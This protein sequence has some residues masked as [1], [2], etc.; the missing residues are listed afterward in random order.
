MIKRVFFPFI[1]TQQRVIT[2]LR[3]LR[4]TFQLLT[5]QRVI[6]RVFGSCQTLLHIVIDCVCEAPV[7]LAVCEN[8]I[9]Y[10]KLSMCSSFRRSPTQRR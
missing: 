8:S 6:G 2:V 5:E 7:T 3:G 9:D 10:C 4:L 1:L